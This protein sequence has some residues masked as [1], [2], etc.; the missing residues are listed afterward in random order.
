MPPPGIE[1]RGLLQPEEFDIDDLDYLDPQNGHANGRE[2]S[3]SLTRRKG[4]WLHPRFV[5]FGLAAVVAL[6]VAGVA[7][8][9]G[10]GWKIPRLHKDSGL[11]PNSDS[12]TFRIASFN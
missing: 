12:S 5:C 10:G 7:L 8:N 2:R 9:K 4:G 3:T 11:L 1:G 6:L